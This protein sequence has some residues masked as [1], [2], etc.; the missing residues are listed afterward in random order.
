MPEA[1]RYQPIRKKAA[2][3]RIGPRRLDEALFDL[4]RRCA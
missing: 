1:P 2:L 3:R 4:Q